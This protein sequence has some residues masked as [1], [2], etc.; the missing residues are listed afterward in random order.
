VSRAALLF[1]AGCGRLAFDPVAD[2]GTSPG[3]AAPCDRDAPYGAPSPVAGVSS[4]TAYEATMRLSVDELRG[5]LWNNDS[6]VNLAFATR[7][8][9]SAPFA[10]SPL[11]ELNTAQYN[12]FEPTVSDD[13][14]VLVFMSNRPAGSAGNNLFLAQR[15]GATGPWSLVGLIPAV[16]TDQDESQP[17]LTRDALYFASNRDGDTDLYRAP[18]LGPTELGAAA[19]IDELS[20]LG[21]KEGDPVVAD[22]GLA[23]Y[24]ASDRLIADDMDIYVATRG[25]TAEPWG[26]P[27]RVAALST[28]A[29]EGPSWISPDGCRLYLSSAVLGTPDIYVARRP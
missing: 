28:A 16:D 5:Y 23:I 7:P 6:G 24:F 29:L 17:Y 14:R 22:D 13:E 3:D 19:R 8:D 12:E 18:R 21:A 15:A 4:P 26:A 2:A 20:Q 27:S 1:L 11:A 25:T 9:A 10:V